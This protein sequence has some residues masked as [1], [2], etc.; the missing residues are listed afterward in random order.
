MK[1]ISKADL[2]SGPRFNIDNRILFVNKWPSALRDRTS[3][4]KWSLASNTRTSKRLTSAPIKIRRKIGRPL[5][6]L[7]SL[8]TFYVCVSIANSGH[9]SGLQWV[10]QIKFRTGQFPWRP[11]CSAFRYM[12]IHTAMPAPT[13]YHSS[14]P[15]HNPFRHVF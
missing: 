13:P 12:Y 3:R 1:S 10:S 7:T 4:S 14:L 15:Q 5:S 6:T 8:L 2:D 9:A 11:C